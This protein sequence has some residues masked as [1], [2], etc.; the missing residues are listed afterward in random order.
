MNLVTSEITSEL[1]KSRLKTYPDYTSHPSHF[2]ASPL[3][4]IDKSDGGKRR[5]HHLSYPTGDP[6]AINSGIPEKYGAIT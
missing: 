2:T 3:G 5:I 6:T 1:S 4:L